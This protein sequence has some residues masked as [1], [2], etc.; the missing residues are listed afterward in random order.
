MSV[1]GVVGNIRVVGNSSWIGTVC[2][3]SVGDVT[4]GC[5]WKRDNFDGVI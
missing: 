5:V 4:N 3:I 2:L 1:V